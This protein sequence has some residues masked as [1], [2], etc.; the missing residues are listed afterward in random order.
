[1]QTKAQSF[2]EAVVNTAFGLLFALII[3]A[4]LFELVE[5]KATAEQN[6]IVVIGMTLASVGRSYVVRRI[7]NLVEGFKRK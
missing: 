5:I 4:L 3:Q 2:L 6:L 7:F 1:M